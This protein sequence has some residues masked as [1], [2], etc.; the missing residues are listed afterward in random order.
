MRFLGLAAMIGAALLLLPIARAPGQDAALQAD[1]NRAI[2]RGVAYLRSLQDKKDGTWPRGGGPRRGMKWAVEQV[3]ATALAGWTL[4]ESGVSPDDPAVRKAADVV[5]EASITLDYTYAVSLAILFLDKL[6]DPGDDVFIEALAVRLIAGMSK[7]GGWDYYCG[8]VPPVEVPRLANHLKQIRANPSKRDPA[9]GKARQPR[10]PKQLSPQ[11]ALQLKQLYSRQP[12]PVSAGDNSN[13]QFAM[14]ALWVARR[15]GIPVA[16][17]MVLV[18]RR[19]RRGQADFGGW[20]YGI[21][22]IFIAPDPGRAPVVPLHASMTCAGLLGVA[23][24]HVGA[25]DPKKAARLDL[26]RDAQVRKGLFAVSALIGEAMPEHS[27]LPKMHLGGR[28][29]YFLWTLARMAV[30]YDLK[31]IGGKDWYVWGAQLLVADQ[32]PDGSWQGEFAAGGCDTCFALLF[33]KRANVAEDLT[34]N[35]KGR[36][37]DPGRAPPQL[38]MMI[39]KA[40][41]PGVTGSKERP[42]VNPEP[43]KETPPVVPAQPAAGDAAKLGDELPGADAARQDALLQKL[44]DTPGTPY[45]QA[46]AGAIPKLRGTAKTRARQALARRFE[47][48][49]AKGLRDEMH[50]PELEI[51]RAAAAAS[52]AKKAKELIPDL[53]HLLEDKEAAVLQAAHSSLRQLTGQDFG[54]ELDATPA[55]RAAAADAWRKWW[56]QRAR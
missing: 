31:T 32:G 13:T 7:E 18:E 1:I 22:D 6:D 23:V 35:L 48:L 21:G 15:H 24:G 52:G 26:T 8:E 16:P 36:V 38:L 14:L 44:R 40:I 4:L 33:L 37:K 39:G 9:E 43:R 17:A 2:D 3:G 28:S 5:R 29:Y 55:E 11:I 12:A 53:I 49:D 27:K 47:A 25:L 19:F 20:G 50:S 10:D 54:P 30:V 42:S 51:R 56:K 34:A 41:G 45:T 46:L